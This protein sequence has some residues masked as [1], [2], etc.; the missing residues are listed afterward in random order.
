MNKTSGKINFFFEDIK[1]IKLSK[2]ILKKWIRQVIETEGSTFGFINIIFCSDEYLLEMNKNYLKHDYYTD[3]ITFDYS[4][5]R[6]LSTDLFISVERVY[7]NSKK[8][9]VDFKKELNRV[10]I[11]G[12][13]HVL[14]YNDK[15]PKQKQLMREKED[16]YLAILEN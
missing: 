1:Q 10:I 12:I 7:D 6:V 14:G 8:V 4:E 2:T 3:I 5:N 16:T 15:S 11:H 13:L 9:S